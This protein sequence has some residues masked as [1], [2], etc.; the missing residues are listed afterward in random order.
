[1]VDEEKKKRG[2]DRQLTKDD[3]EENVAEDG[4]PVK[5]DFPKADAETMS[6][7]RIL[8]AKR[9]EDSSGNETT[10][11]TETKTSETETETTE[12]E[13]KKTNPFADALNKEGGKSVFGSGFKTGGFG[14]SSNSG[15]K[16]SFGPGSGGFG[17]A[18]STKDTPSS[19]G[20]K[21]TFSFGKTD[22]ASIFGNNASSPKEG[23]A[24]QFN[25]TKP[26]S[27]E[28]AK[29]NTSN[30]LPQNV[31]VS[32]G[33]EG[34]TCLMEVRVRS[35][36]LILEEERKGPKSGEKEAASM[37]ALSSNNSTDKK[38]SADESKKKE[39]DVK[40]KEDNNEK[41]GDESKKEEE[42]KKE[43]DE[44][45]TSEEEPSSKTDSGDKT[46]EE[47]KKSSSPVKKPL[48]TAISSAKRW[49]EI[50][51][52]PL[53]VLKNSSTGSTRIVQRRE[54]AEGGMGTR[55]IINASLRKESAITRPSEKHLQLATIGSDSTPVFFLFKARQQDVQSL[56]N[57]LEAEIETAK[58]AVAE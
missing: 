22:N 53:R 17:G 43:G 54:A 5:K 46:K 27:A 6:K 23:A 33:E 12:T 20:F 4:A 18:T 44:E 16:F 58:S 39:K 28:K 26:S 24:I 15:E 50:G 37:V 36:E 2:A 14:A 55:V 40:S 38:D 9:P 29:K 35:Y 51:V 13:A 48:N 11:T 47:D 3:D 56:Q 32:N 21:S 57:L 49:R 1:M 45:K 25:F 52:G 19:F 31:E 41:D 10:T 8:K 7:R 42:T 30:V 34:E